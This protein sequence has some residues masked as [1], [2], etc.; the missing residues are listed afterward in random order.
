MKAAV[1]MVASLLVAGLLLTAL[2]IWGGVSP[3]EA[4]ERVSSLPIEAYALALTVHVGIYLLRAW[5]F[6]VLI[7]RAVRPSYARSLVSSSAHNLASYVLPAKTGEASFVVYMRTHAAVP[8]SSGLASLVVSRVLDLT[9]MCGLLGVTCLVLARAGTYPKLWWLDETGLMLVAATGVFGLLS[10]RVDLLA[11]LVS[12]VARALQFERFDFG[13]RLLERMGSVTEALRIAG[14]SGKLV[15]A[16]FLTVPVWLG[17]FAFYAVLAIPMGLPEHIRF[18]EATFGSS[19]AMLA[20]LL[21]IN[22]MAGFGTQE[23]GWVVGFSALGIERDLALSTGVG[24]HLV[25]L[26]NVCA[27][28]LAAHLAMGAMPAAERS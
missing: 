5:R 13:R 9:I 21:P 10:W 25:Q 18:P 3:A 19:L 27:M 24:V 14:G 16:A 6:R 26:F 28:G 11:R 2:M 15:Y 20:N 17:V 8:A 1:R 4:F 23:A 12:A 7:P 22:G